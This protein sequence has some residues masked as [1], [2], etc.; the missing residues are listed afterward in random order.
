M[1]AGKTK[2]NLAAAS[3][4]RWT[5]RVFR[6]L[7]ISLLVLAILFVV[8]GLLLLWPPVQ[9]KVVHWLGEKASEELGTP[10][11]IGEVMLSPWG[12]LVFND[13]F[14]A[15]LD[16]DTLITAHALRV[17]ALRIHPRSRV[18]AVGGLQLTGARFALR[19]PPGEV[20][21][22]L[23]LL[24][25][26][27]ATSD[28]SSSGGDW[29]VRCKRFNIEDL[30]FSYHNANTSPIPFG[31]D[32]EHVNVT[33]A[34]IAGR[35]LSVVGDSIRANLFR[36][37]LH[38]RSGLEV[39]ELRGLAA[40]SGRGIT[41]QDLHLRTPRSSAEGELAFTTEGWTDYN[42]FNERVRMKLRL[43]T[44]E[45]D[46]A[47]IALFA[48]EL[49]GV[50]YPIRMR[51]RMRGTV[52]ELKGRDMLVSFGHRSYFAGNAELSG[53]PDITNTFMVLDINELVTDHRDL[54]TLPVPPFTAGDRLVLPTEVAQLGTI[55]FAGNFTGF[56]RAFTTYGRASTDLGV[57]NTD[58]SYE[59]DT[60]SDVFTITGRVV[61]PGF[62]LGPLAGTS[63]LGPVAANV[64]VKAS[65]RS[66]NALKADLE[67]TLPMLTVNQRRITG[68]TA[69]GRLERN[70]FNGELTTVDANLKM[71]FKGLA[72]L[73]KRWPQVDFRAE[74]EHMDLNALGFVDAPGYNSLKVDIAASGRLSPDSLSG[75]LMLEDISYC[76]GSKDH[77][78]GDVRLRSGRE[79]GQNVLELN[80]DFADARVEGEFM[81]TRVPGLFVN[82]LYSVFPALQREVQYAQAEQR[83]NF[84]VVTGE[85]APVLDLVAPGLV[86]APGSVIAGS[87]DSKVF[88]IDVSADIPYFDYAG[89]R[90]DSVQVIMDKTLDVLAF[91][92]RSSAQRF[93]DGTWFSGTSAR[94][95]AYQDEVELAL[96]WTDSN[97]G[98]NG[99]LDLQGQVHGPRSVDLDL[100]PSSLFFGRGNW[101]NTEVAHIAIDSSD[102]VL[103]S[104]VL[105]NAGQRIA[106]SGGVSRDPEQALN[107]DLIDV[108]LEN[109][110]PL[111]QGPLIKGILGG[112]GRLFDV[113]GT[114]Y[115]TSYLCADS[116]S[117]KESPIGDIRFSAGWSQ[118]SGSIDLNGEITRGSIKALDFMGRMEPKNDNKLDVDLIFD[119]FDLTFIEPYLPEGISD[120][121][122][123]VTGTVAV[124]GELE[125][126]E[127]NGVVDLEDA[128]LR[129]DYLNT[130]YTFTH[131]VKIAPDM[132]ALDLVTIRDEEGHTAKV[133]GTILHNGLKDWNFNVWG[134]MH[135]LMVLNTTV[136][137]NGLYYGKAYA[138]GDLEVSGSIDLLEITVDASTGPGTD[139][140]FPVG[141]STEISDVGFVQFTSSD[142]TDTEEQV[143]DLSGI[144][145]DMKVDVTPDA[146]MELIFDPT[147]GDIMSGRGRGDIEMNVS[148]AGEFRMLG[149]VEITEGD[150]LFTL[151]NVVNK[152]FVVIPGG[153]IVWFGD[154]FDAQLDLQAVYKVRAPLYDIM[155]EKNEAYKKRVPVDVTMRL[156]DK[157]MNPEI[158][159]EVRLPTVDENTRTQVSSVL[160]TE[161]EL[162]RQVFSLIVL[163]RFI[164]PQSITGAG[165]PGSGG[166]VA[167]T[168]GSELLSNQVSNWL[169]KLSDDFDLGV[170]YRP[171]DNITQDEL[172]VAMSTQLFNERLLL[173][174]NV[175]VS[176]G[177]QSNGNNANNL[178]G[179]FQVE[180]LLTREDRL[181]LKV[182]SMSNDRNLT[183]SDQATTT[184]GAGITYREEF[185]TWGELW[186]KLLN[187][188]RRESKDRKFD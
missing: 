95:I 138:N 40:V 120:I 41:I 92:A 33:H 88:D 86:L 26:R 130:L 79:A 152:K 55:R 104:L 25:D 170:N 107:F 137:D 103:D 166:N 156:R 148:Q 139:I 31:V 2:V 91:S 59:R 68:I 117:V 169:S 17:K 154:P 109:L 145:L 9:N 168:T 11:S 49:E 124:T 57:I 101:A 181:R 105:F 115:L 121:Q 20:K 116:V 51:G 67:G 126:P 172:E 132:F 85:T 140:H 131:Q 70:L 163:N 56:M 24:L 119:Q 47:D 50:E 175:G 53:L 127:V 76:T 43:D 73:R 151:R 134:E 35:E 158:G 99:H 160:S 186:Q 77:E 157:L 143:I 46:F 150:Y 112:E 60:V 75:W 74:V 5:K 52:A 54:S 36:F 187:N 114:P 125:Q 155:F 80:S 29:T 97:G 161:Q 146:R 64:R 165:T 113:Y 174:T 93:K 182:F 129:I 62:D 78:L 110:E 128:G 63:T 82:T 28:T 15:D 89:A 123:L 147:V 83:F 106:L 34:H 14:I 3:I 30:H 13:V 136:N 178:I 32:F 42:D 10:V 69:N 27:L 180:Y 188:F 94:G 162:N 133:G 141:G 21:S 81:P 185:S 144:A 6:W 108:R 149:Q 48:P 153:R 176:Y 58:V 87:M 84:R 100:L 177:A 102:I 184:Q 96:G 1:E 171:G 183:R 19:T 167:G 44:A 122:G 18:I 8:S 16:G 111:L 179:D 118:G 38:E 12:Q 71:H 7:A 65:G 37:Q 173:S 23:T 164:Q 22:N 90:F 135:D 98:T 159:F 142:T 72:D 4:Y 66:F 45:V 39:D 61:S